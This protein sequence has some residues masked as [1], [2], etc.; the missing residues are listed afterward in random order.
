MQS[1]YKPGSLSDG[2][3]EILHR[4]NHS[5]CTMTLGSNPPLIEMSTRNTSWG[6][7]ETGV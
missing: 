6:V 7:K 4:Y 1:C 2:V 3:I 5:G